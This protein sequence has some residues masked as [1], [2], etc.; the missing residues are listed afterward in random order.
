MINPDNNAISGWEGIGE[1][2]IAWHTNTMVI[3]PDNNATSGWEGIGEPVIAWHT[4]KD[5]KTNLF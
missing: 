5:N 1:P 2:V 4:N 3:N